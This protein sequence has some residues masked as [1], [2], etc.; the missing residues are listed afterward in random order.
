[1]KKKQI[2]KP[3][4]F[5][6]FVILFCSIYSLYHIKES[7]DESKITTTLNEITNN[8]L[9]PIKTNLIDIKNNI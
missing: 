8:S 2:R 1:M 7:F 6:L 4:L 5:F 9:G 3:I